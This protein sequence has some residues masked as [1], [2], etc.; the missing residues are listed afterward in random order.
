LSL[1]F[2]RGVVESFFEKYCNEKSFTDSTF[3]RRS[4]PILQ[5]SF[6]LKK[7]G[8]FCLPN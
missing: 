8:N 2:S 5:H 1:G 6:N 7:C 4:F 3:Q